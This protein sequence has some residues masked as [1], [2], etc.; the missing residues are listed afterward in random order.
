MR[1]TLDP[2][3]FYSFLQSISNKKEVESAL[4][5]KEGLYQIV[6]PSR[7]QLLGKS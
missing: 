3:K 4:I 6:D 2:D 1:S 5:N 7:G